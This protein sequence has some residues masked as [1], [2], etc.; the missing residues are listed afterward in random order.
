MIVAYF[1]K[2]TPSRIPFALIAMA[3]DRFVLRSSS[4]VGFFKSLGTGKGETFTPADANALRWGLIAEVK[5]LDSFDQSFVI[6]QW[7]KNSV[8]EF[9]AVIEPI[10]SHGKWAGKEPFSPSVQ[11]WDG[12][13][14]AITRA[15]IAWLQNMRF[16]RAVPPVTASLKSAPGLIA[17]IGI[18][19][20]PIGLQGT[21]SIWQSPAA[22]R[23]FAYRGQAHTQAIAA[24]AT[25]KWY[26]EELFSRFAVRDLRGS[27]ND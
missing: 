8:S 25:Y 12:Q 6:K 21:F 3:M 18:G 20:A 27:I 13:V 2:I 23:D 5:D 22:L 4:N 7:R 14:I 26:S 19:E 1:W 17:A 24:T 10:A 16:W 15:R 11:N 9:R